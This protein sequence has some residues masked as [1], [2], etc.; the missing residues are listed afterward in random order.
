MQ[1]SKRS[2]PTHDFE[3]TAFACPV[4]ID[5]FFSHL[6]FFS[7]APLAP[8]SKT[9][10]QTP[11]CTITLTKTAQAAQPRRM[12][13]R[14]V[15]PASEPASDAPLGRPLQ[16]GQRRASSVV[17]KVFDSPPPHEPASAFVNTAFR[18]SPCPIP[19]ALLPRNGQVH[20]HEYT[21]V[22]AVRVWSLFL[23]LWLHGVHRLFGWLLRGHEQHTVHC[24]RCGN[25]EPDKI[26]DV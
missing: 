2:T 21:A 8:T 1:G 22:R 18:L 4:T 11:R 24:L 25:L 17:S 9:K 20:K 26:R 12:A 14:R 13:R 16:K 5:T 6:S 19:H 10:P 7:P 15:P 3:P 23:R